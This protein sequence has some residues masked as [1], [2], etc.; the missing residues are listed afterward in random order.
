MQ[1]GRFYSH[2]VCELG[3]ERTASS[4]LEVVHITNVSS[5]YLDTNQEEQS[6]VPSLIQV[7]PA[8]TCKDPSRR[9]DEGSSLQFLFG[10][11]DLLKNVRTVAC[12]PSRS[13]D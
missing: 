13:S 1:R 12:M 3:V 5:S 9:D 10:V 4:S 7:I 2:V 6:D 11:S 8:F